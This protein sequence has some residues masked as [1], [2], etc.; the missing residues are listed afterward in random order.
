MTARVGTKLPGSCGSLDAQDD[1]AKDFAIGDGCTLKPRADLH[2]PLLRPPLWPSNSGYLHTL[3]LL[4]LC[5]FSPGA[6]QIRGFCGF[7]MPVR[8]QEIFV[9]HEGIGKPMSHM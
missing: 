9:A 2:E 6:P 4:F 8:A 7:G 1:A 3:N 5:D